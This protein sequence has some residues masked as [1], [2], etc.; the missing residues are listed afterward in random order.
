[1]LVRARSPS[2]SAHRR[3]GVAPCTSKPLSGLKS[4]VLAAST[5]TVV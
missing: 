1:M 3:F 2:L 5:G 4:S